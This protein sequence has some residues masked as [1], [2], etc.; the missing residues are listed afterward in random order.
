MT[1]TYKVIMNNKEYTMKPCEDTK[2]LFADN[3]FLYR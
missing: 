2:I 1:K 3:Q